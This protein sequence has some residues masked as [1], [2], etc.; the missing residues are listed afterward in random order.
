[1]RRAPLGRDS[2]GERAELSGPVRREPAELFV[3]GD[4]A[5]GRLLSG[6]A[7]IL[8]HRGNRPFGCR[9][10]G[11]RGLRREKAFSCHT[12]K[13]RNTREPGS[14]LPSEMI[15]FLREPRLVSSSA[16]GGVAERLRPRQMARALP[17]GA[18]IQRREG[19]CAH[20]A[21]PP[22]RALSYLIRRLHMTHRPSGAKEPQAS[23][24]AP[25]D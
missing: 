13:L 7:C 22:R 10:S 19:D 8:A 21:V 25:Q 20:H 17:E 14:E 16:S 11:S 9:T 18:A 12:T 23:R 5:P 6:T 3:G 4:S 15:G 2:M 24:R 1:M